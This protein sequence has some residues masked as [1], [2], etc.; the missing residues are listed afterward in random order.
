MSARWGL[1]LFSILGVVA[2]V[3]LVRLWRYLPDASVPTRPGRAYMNPRT[4]IFHLMALLALMAILL[5]AHVNIVCGPVRL[6]RLPVHQWQRAIRE[7][8]PHPVLAAAGN[9]LV[10]LSAGGDYDWPDGSR[11]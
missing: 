11:E 1:V 7:S 8:H 2:S 6:S 4:S 10:L 9:C 3:L 5:A